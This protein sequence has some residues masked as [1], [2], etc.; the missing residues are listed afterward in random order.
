MRVFLASCFAAVLVAAA[1]AVVL[2][3][4]VPDTASRAFSTPGA[5]I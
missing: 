4:Y 3:S 5:R 1:A 2:R